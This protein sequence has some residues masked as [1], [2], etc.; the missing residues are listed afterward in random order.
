MSFKSAPIANTKS[1]ESTFFF[2]MFLGEMPIQCVEIVLK[3]LIFYSLAVE[4]IRH[5]D[6]E[7]KT[8]K[9]VKIDLKLK[10]ISIKD[11]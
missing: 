1:F 2:E 9:W 3:S 10:E 11:R 6:A 8:K 5:L 7:I 4:L